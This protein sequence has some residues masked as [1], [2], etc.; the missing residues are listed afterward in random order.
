MNHE[1]HNK[2]SSIKVINPDTAGIDIGASSHFIAVPEGRDTKIVREFGCFTVDIEAMIRWLRSCKIKTVVM[3]S[4]GSYWIPVFEMLD[5]AGFE[6]KLVDAHH[7][8]NVRGRKS[9]II[10]CQWLQQLD[11]HGL[12]SGAFRPENDIVELRSYLRQ[13]STL[14]EISA[15]HIQH[16]QKALIQM[17]I[18]LN[19]AI[20]DITG[21]TGMAIIRSILSG[22]RDLKKLAK[23]KDPRCHNPEDVIEKSLQ[24]NYRKE[25]LF[26]LK[27]A[28]EGYDFY[29]KKISECDE[30]IKKKLETLSPLQKLTE[31]KSRKAKVKKNEYSFNVKDHL[32]QLIG[33]DLTTVPGID[34]NTALKLISEIGTDITKWPTE[35]HFCAWLGLCPGTKISGGRRLSSH[36]SHRTNKAAIAL[37][38]SASS[39]YRSKTAFGA[40]LRKMKARMG[41]VE[42]VTATA[43]KMGRAIYHMML[44]RVDFHEAGADFYE[45]LNEA[46][47][48]KFLKKRAETLGYTLVKVA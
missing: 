42:A 45:K 39:L 47:T 12:L 30:E 43:H 27:Q 7:V 31:A 35:K 19:N 14:I 6:V 25:H 15:M 34:V 21:V 17:N 20:S 29:Q 10:D 44:K 33:V 38:M 26:A 2:A 8:K 9:D 24:G 22:E 5:Q 23:M 40:F 18:H 46:K 3:E 32:K 11:A 41:P 48:L 4:T 16:M 13:R 28:V 37:R 36:T 1:N